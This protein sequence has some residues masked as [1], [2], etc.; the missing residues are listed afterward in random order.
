MN[1][2]PSK[3]RFSHFGSD[4][5]RVMPRD[6]SR[7]SDRY[8]FHGEKL[9]FNVSNGDL[10]PNYN[11]R[12]YSKQEFIVTGKDKVEILVQLRKY[13]L[14]HRRM[15]LHSHLSAEAF[16]VTRGK[17]NTACPRSYLVPLDKIIKYLMFSVD[18]SS[19]ADAEHLWNEILCDFQTYDDDG[20]VLYL[21]PSVFPFCVTQNK[22][23]AEVRS[24][25]IL[26][27][28]FEKPVL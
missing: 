28:A 20:R 15:P 21:K 7:K 12:K 5:T 11:Q 23:P 8:V 14:K 18:W 19:Q 16:H 10:S 27:E 22:R 3:S 1:G 4:S 2:N 25:G 17:V 13:R 24:V 6:N 9:L 26:F